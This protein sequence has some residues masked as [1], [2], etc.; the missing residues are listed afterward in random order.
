[1]AEVKWL[2]RLWEVLH[3]GRANNGFGPIPLQFSE[4][5]AYCQMTGIEMNHWLL[6]ILRQI[7]NHWLSAWAKRHTPLEP[8][9][10]ERR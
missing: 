10:E 1:M 5:A 8:E 3:Q 9:K 6:H 2:F 7:D 4:V